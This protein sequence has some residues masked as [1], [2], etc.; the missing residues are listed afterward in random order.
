MLQT[1]EPALMTPPI[2]LKPTENEN[3]VMTYEYKNSGLLSPLIHE[4]SGTWIP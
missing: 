2:F 4:A 3:S 1:Q